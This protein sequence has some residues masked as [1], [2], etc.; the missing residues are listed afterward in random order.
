M[1]LLRVYII[2]VSVELT[3]KNTVC[4]S[5]Q[6]GTTVVKGQIRRLHRTEVLF[7][8][9]TQTLTSVVDLTGHQEFEKV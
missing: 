7:S 2:E 5:C 3:L 6:A 4:E 8:S 1:R 9:S